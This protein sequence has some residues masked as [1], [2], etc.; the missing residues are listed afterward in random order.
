MIASFVDERK[1]EDRIDK[2]FMPKS[3]LSV[4]LKVTK[5]LRPFSM[6]M[7]AKGFEVRPLFLS[8]AVTIYAWAT[9]RPWEKVVSVSEIAEGDLTM[10]ILRT[11]DN[12]RHIRALKQ[13]F[14]E[15][16]ETAKKSIEL[17]VKEPVVSDYN[18][19]L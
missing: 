1:T 11:A 15:A 5:A 10:L 19:N 18:V 2:E 8:P 7:A 14:P 13:V 6:L 9:G 16:A 12:L 3:L 17:I 4:F